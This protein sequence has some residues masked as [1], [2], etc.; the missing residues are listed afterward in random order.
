[1]AAA[2]TSESDGRLNIYKKIK[3]DLNTESYVANGRS[4]CVRRVLVG[5]QT[6][7]LLLAVKTGRYV[8]VPF[9]QWMC[10]VCDCGEVEDQ[11]HFFITCPAFKI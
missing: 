4:V 5:L 2:E 9:C 11:I 10:R 8:G 1:M 3:K 7:C 6:G